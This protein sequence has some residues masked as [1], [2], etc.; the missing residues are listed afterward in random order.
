MLSSQ[1]FSVFKQI[2]YILA[3]I[4]DSSWMSF[5]NDIV[6]PQEDPLGL[7]E[8]N[9]YELIMQHLSVTDL[10]QLSETSTEFNRVVSSSKQMKKVAIVIKENWTREFEFDEHSNTQRV[11]RHLK[12]V[13]LLRRREQVFKVIENCSEFLS[14]IDTTFDFEMNGLQ[15]PSVSSLVIRVMSKHSHFEHGLLTAVTNLKKLELSGPMKYP[16]NVVSCLERN[17][18]ME[19]L[20]LSNEAPGQVFER[21]NRQVAIKLKS[22]KLDKANFPIPF[23]VNLMNFL[24][25]NADSIEELKLLDCDLSFIPK[26]FNDLPKLRKLT[27]SPKECKYIPR[28][29][30]VPNQCI[31]ELNFIL[32]P[33]PLLQ[34]L[35]MR[36]KVK[37]LY[38][39]NLTE[40]MYRSVL[41][42]IPTMR[43]FRYAY[44][45][46]SNI[47]NA[48]LV[49][50]YEGEKRENSRNLN[51]H[52]ESITQI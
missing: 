25:H 41:Y 3:A 26:V 28:M 22:L 8:T 21:L 9:M 44:I 35:L 49:N 51:Q 29:K 34:M 50:Y 2:H 42:T 14:S 24:H 1:S 12:V 38:I 4:M 47:T 19:E 27:L 43:E 23:E 33:V 5:E 7:R 37:K 52:I 10:L 36:T 15:L 20:I 17:P 13:E 6:T 46:H 30:I 31:E 18:N 45:E 39:S 16:E 40:I 32:T 48:G 11:Y